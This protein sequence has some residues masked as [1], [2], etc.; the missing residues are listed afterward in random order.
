MKSK[1]KTSQKSFGQI[2]VRDLKMNKWKYIIMLPVIVYFILF[3]YKPMYGLL[4]AFQDYVPFKGMAGSKWVG[5]KHFNTFFHDYYFLRVLRNTVVISFLSIVFGFPAPIIFAL[6]LNEVRN[7]GFKRTVQTVTYLPHFISMVIVC[8]LIKQFCMSKG[9][10]NAIIA[11]FGGTTKNLLESK[12]FFYPI[13]IISDIWQS[14][15][16]GSIIY[17]AAIAGVDQEQY[18]SARMDGAGRFQKMFYITLP[19]I[20][21]TITVLFIMRM[22]QVLNV[23]YENILLLYNPK[24]YAVAD[25]IST[26][27]YRKG[28]QEAQWSF[29]T[30][31]GLFNSIVNVLFL[32]ITN[33]LCKKANV[34]GLF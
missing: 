12:T 20:L 21:P 9:A 22:G 31:V 8:G 2:L 15:G 16:W 4:I 18:E 3:A 24:T 13:Y 23:G 10:F 1:V 6:L 26:Y 17:L 25:V 7:I 14:V 33:T 5:F 29:S 30:A 32:F 34:G 27:V 11:A 28:L 19:S